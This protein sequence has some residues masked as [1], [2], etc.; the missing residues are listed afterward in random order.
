MGIS[1]A[2]QGLQGTIEQPTA[3]VIGGSL[4]FKGGQYLER[5][6]TAGNQTTWTWSG[7]IKVSD[8]SGNNIFGEDGGYPN[9][10]ASFNSSG[11]LRFTAAAADSSVFLNIIPSAKFRDFSA[12]YHFVIVYDSGKS[13]S[14][15][16]ARIYV[17]GKRI[18]ALSTATY[19]SQ[20]ATTV[21][22]SN[23][24]AFRIGSH[25]GVDHLQG[26]MSDTY[27]IDGLALGP[28]YF[29]F[30]DPLTNTWRPKKFRADGTTVNDGTAWSSNVTSDIYAG[31]AANVFN[32]DQ[33]DRA[34]IN[35][36]DA[37]NNHFTVSSINSSASSV[38]VFVSNSGS[39]IEV[40]VN[41][42]LVG[43]V[44]SDKITSSSQF[45]EFTFN[46]TVVKSIKVRRTGST[47]GWYLYGITLDGVYM[48]DSTTTNLDFGT[49]G[50][51]LPMDNQ[52]DF[53][54]DRSGKGHIFTKSGFSGTSSDPDV[55]K[56]SPS[57]VVFGDPPTS[58]ITTTSSAP[59][60]YCTFN[61]GN[62]INCT[63]SE[64]GLKFVTGGNNSTIWSTMSIPTSGK[65]CF[66]STFGGG[67]M[68]I[69]LDQEAR[70][71]NRNV[72]LLSTG[73]GMFMYYSTGSSDNRFQSNSTSVSFDSS[74]TTDS[75][76]DVYMFEVDM[77]AG[78]VRVR[79][80]DGSD[81]G[82]YTMPDALKAAPLFVGF[83]VTTT[84]PAV[85]Q[86]FNFGQ[87][88]FK[89]TPSQGFLPL[90]SATVRPETVIARPDQ[91]VGI[92]TYT[93]NG[94]S[95]YAV[96]GLKFSPDLIYTKNLDNGSGDWN[97]QDTVRGITSV[98]TPNENYAASTQTDNINSVTANGFTV[99]T[100]ARFNSGSQ[101][102]CSWV[103]K[104][105]GPKFGKQGADEFWIDGKNYASA[106]AAGL[107]GGT[108]TPTGASV[109]TKQGF[110][111]IKYTGTGLAATLPHG[112]SQAP[113][114]LF[115]KNLANTY[116]WAVYHKDL[117]SAAYYLFL[118]NSDGQSNN[119]Y[120]FW[121]ST[122]PTST[123][124]SLGADSSGTNLNANAASQSHIC[125][126]W[127]SVPGL[128]KFGTYIG[129]GNAD[130]SYI[131]LGFRPSLVIIKCLEGQNYIMHDSTRE[132][133]NPVSLQVYPSIANAEYDFAGNAKDLLSNGFKLRGTNA[134]TNDTDGTTKYVYMAWAEAPAS[135]LFGG[136]S[137]AR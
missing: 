30:T 112:L 116:N 10:S 9:A 98:L 109:G 67:D 126:A 26:Y 56:D 25:S 93:S 51:Y 35:N 23:G 64:A 97:L 100:G 124:I 137:N 114:F 85:T 46:T 103:W 62:N 60:N 94:G 18:T 33:T 36:A 21:V 77:D 122:D 73:L 104:A 15:E 74:F 40:S 79:K 38:G 55:V 134:G 92:V 17:N 68:A 39:D 54:K 88:P 7:W 80:D 41:D 27:L 108:I 128:Q 32:S 13:V 70:R 20:S 44:P 47:S 110:S 130:G 57:G 49:N 106:A 12:W 131:E 45:F 118:N 1:R 82:L 19:P 59:A 53:E 71:A 115:V 29:G 58:G 5:T 84:W 96:T 129:N 123:V 90:N 86:T 65:Y 121:N 76:G 24:N 8:L 136:Q 72:N 6:S 78:T 101:R 105:G 133:F 66:E 61:S 11:E 28:G 50:F 107:N 34:E 135:N 89:N 99:G 132:P 95:A 14:S 113:E 42:I 43:T 75:A 48:R 127:H 31:S 117:T 83:T 69:M 111:I 2:L 16:R 63:L 3:Q 81:S 120:T 119:F 87:K 37:N 102:I 125:Y 52:D 91:Y 22:N 4:K